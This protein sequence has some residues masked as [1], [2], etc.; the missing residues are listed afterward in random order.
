[1]K[2]LPLDVNQQTVDQI[3]WQPLIQSNLPIWSPLLSNPLYLKVKFSCPDI[4]NFIWIEPLLRDLLTCK[5]TFS[6]SQRWPLNTSLTVYT[7]FSTSMLFFWGGV[8]CLEKYS[9]RL[10]YCSKIYKTNCIIKGYAGHSMV[11]PTESW[12]GHSTVPA[13]LQSSLIGSHNWYRKFVRILPEALVTINSKRIFAR[14]WSETLVEIRLKRKTCN[15]M[16]NVQILEFSTFWPLSL[17]VYLRIF[18]R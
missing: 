10:W 17:G 15:W 16:K 1:M 2:Y 5:T 14:I 12:Q 8:K 13:L 11:C 9:N 6:L 18:K 7:F 3:H 4:E